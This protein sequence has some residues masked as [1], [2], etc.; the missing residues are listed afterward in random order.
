MKTILGFLVVAALA[1][2]GCGNNACEDA[3]DKIEEC[4]PAGYRTI[5]EEC[6][7]KI[8]CNAKCINDATC[9]ELKSSDN[10]SKYTACVVKCAGG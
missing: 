10:N 8:E 7:G 6:S 3:N 4:K 1:L 9:D 5:S 2:G